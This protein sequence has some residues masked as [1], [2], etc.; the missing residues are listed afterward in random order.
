MTRNNNIEYGERIQNSVSLFFSCYTASKLLGIPLFILCV[1]DILLRK[2]WHWLTMWLKHKTA[3]LLHYYF[4]LRRSGSVEWKKWM[5]YLFKIPFW[6]IVLSADW[7]PSFIIV[8]SHDFFRWWI[9]EN[10]ILCITKDESVNAP[11]LA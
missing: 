10:N 3:R 5:V 8:M 6:C 7:S 1:Y 11:K 4:R 2:I 9:R